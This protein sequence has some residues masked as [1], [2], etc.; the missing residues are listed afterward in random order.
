MYWQVN[1]KERLGYALL[2]LLIL[3]I[4][5]VLGYRASAKPA[6][7]SVAPAPI[8]RRTTAVAPSEK[9]E[10]LVVHVVGAVKAPGV[11]RLPQSSRAQ[12]AVRAAGGATAKANLQAINLAAKLQDGEQLRVPDSSESAPPA[13]QAKSSGKSGKLLS[14]Q[15]SLNT[16]SADELRQVPGIGPATADKIIA[17]R[18]QHGS[19]SSL[20]QLRDVGGIGEKKLARMAP[21]LKL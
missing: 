7:I 17:Y 4:A 20:E 11:Y 12:D 1:P 16:A 19:F 5:G 15:V 2:A 8:Q 18:Q 3:A 21:Y 13:A 9:S 10:E 6:D 14:G